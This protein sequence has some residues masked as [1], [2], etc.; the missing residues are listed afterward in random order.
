MPK[1]IV[2][3]RYLKSG[4]KKNLANYVRYVATREG[5]VAVKNID[6]NAP[7]T[8]NQQELISSL[9]NDF[10]DSKELFEYE[11]YV[12][13]PNFKNGSA[14]ISEVI[15][16]NMDRLTNR[17]NYVGYFANRP[18]SVKFGSHGLFNEKNDPID[19]EKVAKE[20]ADHDGNV[21]THVVSL[22]R[23]DA[24]AMGYDN[25]KSWRELVKRQIPN[26]AKN[27]KIN[28]VN[29]KWYA[30][31]HD[32][33]TNPHVHII[34]YS[35]NEREGFLTNH[36]IEKIRSE[37]AND[38]YADELHHLYEQQT[39]LR[40]LLKK[41]SEQLMKS[42][43][44]KI[45]KDNNFNPE[46]MNLVSKLHTQL[47]ETKGKKV[48]G[49]LKSDVKKTVD[50]IFAK[51]ADNESVKNMYDLWCE[52]EQQKHDVYS[53]AKVDFPPLVD[54]KEFKSVKNMIIQT[55]LQMN[56]QV[57]EIEME[58]P[59]PDMDI[60]LQIEEEVINETVENSTQNKLYIK[61]NDS[62]KEAHK[63]ILNNESTLGDYKKAEKLLLS[64]SN[65]VLAL[66]DLGKL[67]SMEKS[68]LK[69]DEKSF[70]FYEKSLQ[71]FI[72]FEPKAKKIKPYLQYQIGM[73][74]LKGLGIPVDNQKAAEYFEKS[75]EL[76]NQYAKRL[77]AF[78]YISGKNFEQ[79][80]KKGIS[81]LTECADG[82]DA[83]SCYKLGNL[84]LKGEIVNQDLN[85]AEKY[86][87]SAE[88]NEFRQHGLGILYLQKE[89]YDIQKA[90][91]Y[92]EKSA[93]KNMHASY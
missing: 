41:E 93:D 47:A 77:L 31:F 8:K 1:I 33:K 65:N 36:G 23:D 15:D 25:L 45:S 70:E 71:G 39:N 64:E 72:Q 89:K 90:I 4:S 32:K 20:V 88:D 87:L 75:A 50:E 7:A 16:R 11:D 37:F 13:K 34:V 22:R 80:N 46:L 44:E 12:K 60:P 27:S 78:E 10:P 43:A 67:Y 73:M 30:A 91:S 55:V 21:Y 61:W 19:L 81:L 24:Q 38:I 76:G 83:F 84:Y 56:F 63:L 59:E 26:I 85:K 69:D 62:N 54:N 92:F 42:L 17:E 51:L 86:L 79:N 68:G 28:M 74:Y 14:L 49:Y 57:P 82:G 6:E 58:M 48:Y 2:T 66:H 5:S 3:S 9:L 29:L 18:G 40:N 53:S 35:N 52:M